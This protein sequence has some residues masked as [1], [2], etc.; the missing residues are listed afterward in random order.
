MQKY[1]NGCLAAFLLLLIVAL[2]VEF[3]VSS[4]FCC[5]LLC[6]LLVYNHFDGEERI[7]CF[8]MFVFLVSCDCYCSVALPNGVVGWSAV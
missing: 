2:I 4:M 1:C 6:V 3:C 8:T 7:G 5:T